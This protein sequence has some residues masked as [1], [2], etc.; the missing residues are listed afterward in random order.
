MMEAAGEMMEAAGEMMEA[1][2]EMMEAAGEMM[3]ASGVM[4]SMYL[5]QP[6]SEDRRAEPETSDLVSSV[7]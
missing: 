5:L 2:G 1:A 4:V 6:L 7:T 3:E